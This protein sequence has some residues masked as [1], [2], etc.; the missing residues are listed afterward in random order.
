LETQRLMEALLQAAAQISSRQE[1]EF[2]FA[3]GR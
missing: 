2:P 1:A 3:S